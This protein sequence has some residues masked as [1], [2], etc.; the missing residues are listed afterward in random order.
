MAWQVLASMMP[1]FVAVGLELLSCGHKDSSGSGGLLAIG[2][3][4][5]ASP[6]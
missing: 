6:V 4:A 2:V 5:P 3:P 1:V